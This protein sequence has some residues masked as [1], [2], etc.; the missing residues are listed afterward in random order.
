MKK[1]QKGNILQYDLVTTENGFMPIEEVVPGM[2]VKCRGEWKEVT[3][4]PVFGPCKKWKAETLPTTIFPADRDSGVV[5]LDHDMEIPEAEDRDRYEFMLRGY[6]DERNVTGSLQFNS[7]VEAMSW[8][9]MAIRFFE[10]AAQIAPFGSRSCLININRK[11]LTELHGEELKLRNLEY[12]LEG[13]MKTGFTWK[14]MKLLVN[15]RM[16]ES[17]RLVRRLLDIDFYKYPY[18]IKF[19]RDVKYTFVSHYNFCKH[20][21]NQETKE[22]LREGFCRHWIINNVKRIPYEDS[23]KMEVED[24]EGWY[25]PGIYPDMN[26]MSASEGGLL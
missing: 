15:R 18:K 10:S 7:F 24:C 11:K 23:M 4:K 19:E 20:F 9:P 1:E 5:L 13:F 26:C 6:F 21:R 22:K 3:E 17:D 25:I 16:T 12:Y 2:K 14:G 8:L